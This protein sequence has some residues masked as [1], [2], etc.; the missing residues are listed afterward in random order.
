M[1]ARDLAGRYGRWALVAGA[2]EGL[3]AAFSEELARRGMSVLMTARRP[4]LLEKAAAG[5]RARTGAE[6]RT[7][8]LDLSEPGSLVKIGKAAEGLEIG[9]L[10]CNAALAYTGRFLDADPGLYSRMID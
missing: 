1:G 3:G 4:E 6:V 7:H 2:S 9:I 10:V 8:A 5:I